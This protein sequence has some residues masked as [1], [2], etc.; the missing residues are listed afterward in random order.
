MVFWEGS[1]APD[2]QL[3]TRYEEVCFVHHKPLASER[4]VPE[5][6]LRRRLS[7]IDPFL[8]FPPFPPSFPSPSSLSSSLAFCILS[9]LLSFL[10]VF[11]PDFFH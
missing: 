10:V 8:S 9:C 7:Q 5:I 2:N 11:S 6:D 4:E 3:G 1:Q